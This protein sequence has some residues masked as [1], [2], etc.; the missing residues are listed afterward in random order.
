[1]DWQSCA[2]VVLTDLQR[3]HP[4]I[5]ALTERLDIMRWGHAMIRPRPGFVW[6]AARR[7]AALPFRGIHFAN[8]DLSGIA[9]FEEA[10]YH[11]VRAAEEVLAENEELRM[12]S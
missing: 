6:S 1:M 12:K 10:F 5:R 8:T 4:N 3:P 9:L 2:D 7:Q 11:G